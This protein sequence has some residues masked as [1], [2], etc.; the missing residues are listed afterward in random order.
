[1]ETSIAEKL[2]PGLIFLKKVFA[3]K[4]RRQGSPKYK[5]TRSVK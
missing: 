2:C 1:L 4:N 3:L 5:Y